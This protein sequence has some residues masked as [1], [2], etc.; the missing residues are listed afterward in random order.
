M[1][2][3]PWTLSLTALLVLAACSRPAEQDPGDMR[4]EL[5]MRATLDMMRPVEDMAAQEEDM[6]AAQ[7]M[8]SA[9]DM[10]PGRC[11]LA[12]ACERGQRHD[13]ECV[14][15]VPID[16]GCERDEDCRAQE[17]CKEVEHTDGSRTDR[18]CWLEESSLS[19]RACPGGPGCASAEGE[20][21]AAARSMVVTPQ[22]YETPTAAG[23]KEDG[24]SAYMNFDPPLNERNAERWHDCGYDGLCPGD[25]GYSAPD[26]GEGD[27]QLQGMFIAGFSSGRPAQFCPEQLIGCA[28]PEC[29][30]SKFA[31]DDL[32]VQIAVLRKGDLTVAFAVV[33][34]V[35]Y[36][37]SYIERIRERVQDEAGVDLL[38]MSATHSHES[39][40]TVGQWGPGVVAPKTH[41]RDP[42]FMQAIEDQAVLGIRQA[43]QELA[44]ARVHVATLNT[45]VQGMAM[46]DSRP[47]YIF[48]DNIPVVTLTHRDTGAPIATL[49]SV[50]NHAEVLWS[51]NKHLTADYFHFARKYVR[52][53]L[54]AVPATP[55]REAKPALAG[56][57]GVTV[58]FAGAVGGLINP[59][60]ASAMNY[61][62]EVFEEHGFAK[63][64]ALGQRI[65]MHVLQAHAQGFAEL[66]SHE[67]SFATK[68]FLVPITNPLFLLAGFVLVV[69]ER[70]IYNAKILGALRFSPDVPQ[71]MSQVAVVRLGPLT[72]FTAPGEIFPETLVG[73]F[74]GRGRAQSPVVGDVE[75]RKT[76]AACDE[77]GLPAPGGTLPCIVKPD[78]ENPPDWSAAPAGPY[79]YERLPGEHPFFI[80]LGMDFLGYMV[81]AYDYE[82]GDAPGAHY[83]ETNGASAV[84]LQK[85]EDN[86]KLTLDALK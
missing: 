79:A 27:G 78:Q 13:R 1:Q 44:P 14:C 59:G 85:W 5:D 7:D 73:G 19:V 39:P 28:Q 12:S 36:F 50:A 47:P 58:M 9:Q 83:E 25:E 60:S 49:L 82:P 71:V 65:A 23:L 17:T 33:D 55:E 11:A 52:E 21:L 22:G 74:P 64:D 40:D 62:G 75:E 46:S 31:H 41:G 16:R 80:G 45:G 15:R 18:V 81:P 10:T 20:L 8:H 56:L 35:G 53:G 26:E 34:A 68:R 54:E 30:V 24:Q 86:L 66:P 70:D 29:C 67:L 77:Q 3:S 63:A 48:D 76:P 2:R 51:G 84:L 6:R 42:R 43:V 72:F 32:K 69:F 4:A 37:H 57:G 61:A 38:I